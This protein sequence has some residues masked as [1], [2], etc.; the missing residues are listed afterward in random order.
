VQALTLTKLRKKSFVI[1]GR[2]KRVLVYTISLLTAPLPIMPYEK[3]TRE[4]AFALIVCG[5]V[6]TL[7]SFYVARG[8]VRIKP[9]PL[10][11]TKL[12]ASSLITLL[13]GLSLLLGAI[14]YLT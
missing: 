10:V 11:G 1:S 3:G 2:A 8:E 5:A 6:L 7:S 14:V 12:L 13:F 4:F 9:R